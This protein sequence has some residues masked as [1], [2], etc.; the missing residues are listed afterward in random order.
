LRLTCQSWRRALDLVAPPKLPASYQLPI[1][2]IQ[3]IFDYLSP[4]DFNAARHTCRSWMRASLDMSLL[5]AMLERGGWP[6]NADL[7]NERKKRA[8]PGIPTALVR[9]EV[10]ILSRHLSRQCALASHWTGNG[11][12][13]RAAIIESSSIYFS[14]LSNGDCASRNARSG[15]LLF[16]LSACGQFVLVARDTLIYVYKLRGDSQTHTVTRVVCPRRVLS[17]SMDASSGRHA[18]AALLEG[19]MGLVCE[20]ECGRKSKIQVLEEVLEKHTLGE[21]QSDM[22]FCH[23]QDTVKIDVPKHRS[24]SVRSSFPYIQ[25][26]GI[27]QI[28]TIDLRSNQDG[29]ALQDV[30]NHH[31]HDHNLINST[32]NLNM[33]GHPQDHSSPTRPCFACV[34][35]ESGTTT[36]YRHLCSEED[37]P[38]SVSICPQRRCVA[39]GCS[40]GIE[41]HW[42]DA[43]TGQSLSR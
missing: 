17:I 8:R 15:G 9:S 28:N 26:R 31:S 32:W 18:L 4:K 36:F 33:H 42:T 29:A 3:H 11:I 6:S 37:P 7:I 19:R 25:E 16:S 23:S 10:W 38:R 2:I 1:E 27:D 43:L 40:A 39:F 41:L 20:L 5:S 34:P 22:T 35:I 13:D 12:D 24:S 14:E 21:A 30:D